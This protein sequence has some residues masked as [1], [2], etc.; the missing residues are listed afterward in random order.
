MA[1]TL[2]M[3][4][5]GCAIAVGGGSRP[6][7]A[8]AEVRWTL[9]GSW[10]RPPNL[11]L[12][13]AKTTDRCVEM[14][15]EGVGGGAGGRRAVGW[16]VV[17][18]CRW[19]SRWMELE[20]RKASGCTAHGPTSFPNFFSS[21]KLRLVTV[22]RQKQL[23]HHSPLP[24]TRHVSQNRL[25]RAD[26]APQDVPRLGRSCHIRSFFEKEEQA[27]ETGPSISHQRR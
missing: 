10:G 22:S 3:G 12:L 16:S 18:E 8:A 9:C 14:C 21:P 11:K 23:L 26:E 7:G 24:A 27:C 4:P 15:A 17:E 19:R 5:V 2:R 20:A 1:V 13:N 6:S 25:S